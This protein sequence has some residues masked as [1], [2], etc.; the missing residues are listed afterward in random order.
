MNVLVSG[1]AGFIGQHVVRAL[2]DANHHPIIFDRHN[3]ADVDVFLGDILNAD[4]VDQAAGHAD[5]IIHLAGVLGTQETIQVPHPAVHTNIVGALHVF[6]AA[7]HYDL[8]LV[9]IAVGNWW[10]DNPYSISKNCAE[11]LA[12]M[13]RTE[14]GLTVANVRVMNAY[15]PRQVPCTP[16]GPSKVRKIAPAFI[17]RA[18][19]GQPVEIYGDGSQVMDMI[20]VEDV[21]DSLVQ[22]VGENADYEC[23]TA[24]PTTV[25]DIAEQVVATVGQGEIVFV[26]MRPGEPEQS[27]VIADSEKV[28]RPAKVTLEDGIGRTVDWYSRY[29]LPEWQS[30]N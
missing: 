20:Y 3:H 26:P 17:C 21:A 16:F 11:R 24:R 1:G 10:M 6:D 15:G 4:S 12:R 7:Q 19:T 27:T 23:G 8:P 9:N 29:W 25:R 13:Y 18:L 28:L 30:K 2:E 22:A 14:H 5:A